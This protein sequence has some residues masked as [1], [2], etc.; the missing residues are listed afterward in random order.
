[1]NK[2]IKSI[3]IL[4]LVLVGMSNVNT[5][6]RNE[7]TLQKDEVRFAELKELLSGG[8]TIVS[9]YGHV[10]LLLAYELYPKMVYQFEQDNDIM[11]NKLFQNVTGNFNLENIIDSLKNKKVVYF[12]H[13]DDNSNIEERFNNNNIKY[14]DLGIYIEDW[15]NMKLYK[16]SY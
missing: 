1:M 14:E 8:D 7:V 10:Q 15:Y 6:I 13:A 5:F 11:I 2:Y 16:L 4:L 3:S 9:D 12:I